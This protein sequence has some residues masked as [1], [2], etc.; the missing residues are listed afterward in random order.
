MTGVLFVHGLWHSAGCWDAVRDRLDV[1]GVRSDAVQLP[2]SSLEDDVAVTRAALDAV[3]APVILVGHSYGGAVVTAAGAHPAVLRLV[4][5]AAFQLAAGESVNRAVPD[6][7]IPP[8]RLG[9]ALR[10]SADGRWCELDP[11]LGAQLLYNG[12]APA[13]T[14]AAVAALR[15]ANRLVFGGVPD[16]IGW[17]TTPSTYVV[18]TEDLTVAPDLQRAMAE[19]ATDVVQWPTGHCP[20]LSRPDLVA[21]L[22]VAAVA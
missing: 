3:D 14:A 13:E 17:Q 10:W 20:M 16:T 2:M 5:V 8:T 6:R 21:D 9:E 1:A 12:L 19:R 22:L 4:Y 18:C 7:D 11:E 15:P